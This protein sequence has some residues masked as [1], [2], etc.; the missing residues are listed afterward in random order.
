MKWILFFLLLPLNLW[1][2]SVTTSDVCPVKFEGRVEL[3]EEVNSVEHSLSK[4]S[5][6]F[7]D[8]DSLK[9][10]FKSNERIEILKHGLFKLE[11]GKRYIVEL[12]NGKVCIIRDVD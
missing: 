10:D 9:G 6:H 12:N 2:F 4:L 7:E 3:I 11:I 1:A 5:V 8:V